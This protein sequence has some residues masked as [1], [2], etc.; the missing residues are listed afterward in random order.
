LAIVNGLDALR[1]RLNRFGAT[2]QPASPSAERADYQIVRG[3][4]A[5]R[6]NRKPGMRVVKLRNG[7]KTRKVSLLQVHVHECRIDWC[8]AGFAD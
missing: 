3:A 8:P 7:A 6:D 5:K 2:Q 1:Q 4:V